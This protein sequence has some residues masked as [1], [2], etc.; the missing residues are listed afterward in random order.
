MYL[1]CLVLG[2]T[3]F[4]GGFAL[5]PKSRSGYFQKV[6]RVSG[7]QRFSLMPNCALKVSHHQKKKKKKGRKERK[8]K[9]EPI[10]PKL[11]SVVASCG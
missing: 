3:D 8:K 9:I 10:S 5:I 6:F 2:R 1:E 11:L 4:I 7:N